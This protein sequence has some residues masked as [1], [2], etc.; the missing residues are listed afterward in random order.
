MRSFPTLPVTTTTPMRA[1][2][3]ELD[4]ISATHTEDGR[5]TAVAAALMPYLGRR[6]LLTPADRRSAA[7]HYRTNVVHVGAGG[8]YSVVALVWRPGQRTPIHSHRSWCVVGVHEGRELERTF[9][10]RSGRLVE[11]G[12]QLIEAGTVTWLA[13]GNDDIHDVSNT[14]SGTTV[15]I[16]VY[17][18]DYRATSSSILDTYADPTTT[19]A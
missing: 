6:D 17:G 19:A 8:A 11:Q 2:I 7:H 13:A 18:L 5:S 16:H 3:A 14:A 1:L 12:Q 4:E 9:R 15:S 10:H